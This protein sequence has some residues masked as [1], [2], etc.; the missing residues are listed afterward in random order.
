MMA[1][2]VTGMGLVCPAGIDVASSWDAMLAGV[3]KASRDP[4]LEGIRVDFSARVPEAFDAAA[5]LGRQARKLER[6]VILALASLKEAVASSELDTST[7][8]PTRVGVVM[9]CGIGGAP[10][11]DEQHE[12]M[13]ER[14]SDRV[15]P[16]LIPR[17]ISN[18]VSG[19][20]SMELGST[21]PNMVTATACASA[22]TA[23]GTALDL[24]RSGRCD[25]VFAGGAEAAITPLSVAGFD[26][27]T[28]LSRNGADP[29]KASRPFDK[30]RDGFVIAEAAGILV[31]ETPEH[32]KA[33]GATPLAKIA[34]YG[35]SA[36]AFHTTAPHPEGVGA[37]QAVKAALADAGLTPE[38]I[39][40][41]NA[42]GTSTPLNDKA[43]SLMIAQTLGDHVAVTSSK[44][45]TGHS[46]G[47]AGAVE[48]ILTVKA[49]TEGVVP[50]TA[51][52]EQLDPE[53]ACDVVTGAP[54]EVEIRAALSN[55]F[56][57]GGQNAVLAITQ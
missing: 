30:D 43:E 6:F 29:S 45:V 2:H 53:V 25:V 19:H 27:M 56:G 20:I 16:H 1:A 49:I 39:Q 46:L 23:I 31:L 55:S 22:T 17:L 42:H 24:L 11:W 47:A 36:D 54:R 34:G 37:A 33:R 21:G 14:G 9:G 35:A 5:L 15:T 32:A 26:N 12:V 40:H 38:D 57:F 3:G 48:A 8:D 50:H 52:C 41:V 7:W 44:G 51:N 28:A 13:R 18:M 4:N 10:I